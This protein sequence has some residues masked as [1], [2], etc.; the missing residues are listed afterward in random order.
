MK[1]NGLNITTARIEQIITFYV[2]AKNNQRALPIFF[3]HV[4][5][6]LFAYPFGITGNFHFCEFLVTILDP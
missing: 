4:C 2:N 6:A 3:I 5:T 1:G